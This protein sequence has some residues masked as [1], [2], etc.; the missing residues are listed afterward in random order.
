[1]NDIT[2][3][4][5]NIRKYVAMDYVAGVKIVDIERAAWRQ[6]GRERP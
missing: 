5:G 1:M 3:K 2:E 6:P 4:I